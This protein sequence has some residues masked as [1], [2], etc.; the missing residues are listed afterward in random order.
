MAL[1]SKKEPMTASDLSHITRGL[2]QAAAATHQVIAQQYIKLFDQF[3]DYDPNDLGTPMKAKMVEVALDDGHILNIPLITLVAP[4]GLALAGMKVD[5]SV[6]MQGTEL[7]KAR[8]KLQNGELQ[9]ERFFVTFGQE[10]RKGQQRD[11]DEI[12]ISMVFKAC[13]PPE[14][15]N[16]LLE[17]YTN[18]ISPIRTQPEPAAIPNPAPAPSGGEAPAS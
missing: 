9:S 4:R 2:H 1:F 3:F 16:R 6:K 7:E 17:E 5:L 12:A 14:A 18:L 8:D 15:V 10:K 13:E 11:P